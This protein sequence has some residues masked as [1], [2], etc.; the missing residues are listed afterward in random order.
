LITIRKVS[1]KKV[2]SNK[3]KITFITG[4]CFPFDNKRKT[5]SFLYIKHIFSNPCLSVS[6]RK[7]L[8]QEQ[9]KYIS[10]TIEAYSSYFRYFFS[11]KYLSIISFMF[12]SSS[13]RFVRIMV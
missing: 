13:F 8:K 10:G 2:N 11:L 7:Q 5:L 12:L 3:K 9:L 1:K 6:F 4:K